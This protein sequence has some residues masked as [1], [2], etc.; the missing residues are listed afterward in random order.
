V[1]PVVAERV[2]ATPKVR[3]EAVVVVEETSKRPAV[4]VE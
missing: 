2:V 4:A 1:L 3:V